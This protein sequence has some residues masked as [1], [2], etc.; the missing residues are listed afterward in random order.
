MLNRLFL[1]L[2]LGAFLA[3]AVAQT[4][5]REFARAEAAWDKD[6]YAAS[7]TYFGRALD[8]ARNDTSD[9]AHAYF[10]RGQAR[11]QQEKWRGARDDLSASIA[12]FPD[13]AEAFA[14]RGMARKSMGDF[15]GL[16][17]DAHRAAQLDPE[18]AGFEDDAKS[19]VL[20]RRAM[21][22]FLI[23]GGIV[24]AIGLVPMVRSIAGAIKAERAA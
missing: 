21:L 7:E 16:L 11:L 17:D 19:T 13:N 4:P 2:L 9:K 12:L 8:L 1:C 23:L 24:L 20:W 15:S 5:A 6:D 10:G 3:P 14:S 18:Y 22:G